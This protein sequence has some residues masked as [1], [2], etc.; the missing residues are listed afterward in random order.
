MINGIRNYD[1]DKFSKLSFDFL[2]DVG[3]EIIAW[4][5]QNPKNQNCGF[6]SKS[7]F[8]M[9][10]YHILYSENYSR[11]IL[12]H[13][14]R[15]STDIGSEIPARRK[16]QIP[17]W[18]WHFWTIVWVENHESELENWVQNIQNHPKHHKSIWECLTS[19]LHTF[20][21]LL[22]CQIVKLWIHGWSWYFWTT[23]NE[24]HRSH[25]QNWTQ[26]ISIIINSQGNVSRVIWTHLSSFKASECDI[27]R[28]CC[29]KLVF[30]NPFGVENHGSEQEN[31]TQK[32]AI[33]EKHHIFAWEYR[34]GSCQCLTLLKV[35]FLD[36]CSKLIFLNLPLTFRQWRN[37]MIKISLQ[38][39]T[40]KSK[41]YGVYCNP[42]FERGE[43][44]CG[45]LG[46]FGKKKTHPTAL[47]MYVNY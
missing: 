10:F 17:G 5:M 8:I 28:F 24:N 22:D 27:F 39:K 20:T 2:S 4:M 35:I 43:R 47:A 14:L 12:K 3:S 41:L 37:G 7:L 36:F 18:N 44:G 11:T 15:F 32:I 33:N 34:T 29:S 1:S 25:Q 38:K 30:L 31:W 9:F 26:I 19:H 16:I 40:F 6:C 13:H 21:K 42:M 23:W 46:F 45:S